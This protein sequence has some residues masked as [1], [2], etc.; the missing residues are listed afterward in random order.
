MSDEAGLDLVARRVGRRMA[1]ADLAAKPGA[2]CYLWQRERA[3]GDLVAAGILPGGTARA[4]AE[5]IAAREYRRVILEA[6]PKLLLRMRIEDH[7]HRRWIDTDS[8]PDDITRRW[9]AACTA[10]DA[11]YAWTAT[12]AVWE[13]V[14]EGHGTLLGATG[15]EDTHHA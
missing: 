7:S 14:S 8:D 6:R 5:W 1:R 15:Q 12:N 11:P 10:G 13:I 4:R 2:T 3:A 9:G